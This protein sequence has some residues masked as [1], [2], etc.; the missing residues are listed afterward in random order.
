M[1]CKM[2]QK[3][4]EIGD[5]E[6]NKRQEMGSDVERERAA[7]LVMAMNIHVWCNAYRGQWGK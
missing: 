6:Q 3:Y 4:K 5:M 1:S 7:A 2:E